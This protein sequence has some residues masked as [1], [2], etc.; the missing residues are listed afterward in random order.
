M[1][2]SLNRTGS[3]HATV[4]IPAYQEKDNLEV[5]IPEICSSLRSIT[6]QIDFT[7]LT[8]LP[9]FAT[10]DEMRELQKLGAK[11]IRRQPGN[12]FGDAIRTGIMSTPKDSL[13]S[14]FM[15]AD[16]SH[17]PHGLMKI[18]LAP[19][20]YHVVVASRYTKGGKSENSTILK[21]MSK[22]L[23]LIYSFVLGIQ[24]L[25][26][27][28]SFK[29]YYSRDLSRLVLEAEHFDIVEEILFRVKVMHCD[30]FQILEIPDTFYTR[31]S[32][33]SKRQLGIF[34]VSYIF[35]LY[36]LRRKYLR[37]A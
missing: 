15:D 8:V 24:C 18:L 6:P 28:N 22:T 12:S 4:I 33:K 3:F 5:L 25:D 10:D 37:T 31:M 34:I 36:K 27:S 32:G 29:R 21:L 11:P 19:S 26:V 17:R 7:I 30:E 20:D 35:S 1:S 2:Q 16:G 9:T 14:I 13:F 23:N